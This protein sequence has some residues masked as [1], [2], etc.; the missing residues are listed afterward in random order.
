MTD[1]TAATPR[2]TRRRP[3]LLLYSY[4]ANELLAPFFASFLTLYCVF[5]LVRLIPLLEIVL[6]LRIGVGDFIR[7]FRI[8]DLRNKFILIHNRKYLLC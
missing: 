4:I 5:F 1:K 2:N 8:F 6:S 3:S 7:L